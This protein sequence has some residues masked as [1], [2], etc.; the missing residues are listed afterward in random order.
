MLTGEAVPV[1]KHAAHVSTQAQRDGDEAAT[2]LQS[3]HVLYVDSSVVSESAPMRVDA[4]GARTELG[5]MAGSLQSP[6]PPTECERG[7][8][9]FGMMLMALALP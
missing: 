8:R 7:T 2:A 9:L 3:P 1:E 5:R 6:A 4:T